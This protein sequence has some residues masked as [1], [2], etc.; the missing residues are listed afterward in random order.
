MFTLKKRNVYLLITSVIVIYLIFYIAIFLVSEQ[1]NMHHISVIGG[2]FILSVA[3][4]LLSRQEQNTLLFSG[5]IMMIVLTLSEFLMIMFQIVETDINEIPAID[6]VFQVIASIALV[7]LITGFYKTYKNLRKLKQITSASYDLTQA[8]YLEYIP[9]SNTIHLEFSNAFCKEYHIEQPILDVD[10]T[11]FDTYIHPEDKEFMICFNKADEVMPTLHSKIRFMFPGMEVYAYM[12]VKGSYIVDD[13]YVCLGFDESTLANTS[14]ALASKVTEFQNL[15]F[16]SRKIIDNTKELISKIALDGTIIYTS[17]AFEKVYP[18]KTGT[19]VGCN[20]F[21]LN[22]TYGH[23]NHSWFYEAIE[24]HTSTQISKLQIEGE[25]VWISWVNDVLLDPLGNVEFIISV[26]HDITEL[27]N[28]NKHLEY[29]ATHN[30]LTGL[31]NYQGLLDAISKLEHL[32]EAHTFFIDLRQFSQIVDYYGVANGESVI[33]NVANSLKRFDDGK[34][35]LCRFTGDQFVVVLVNPYEDEVEDAIS[36]LN[37]TIIELHMIESSQIQIK[38]N[39]GY[40]IYP[41]DGDDILKLISL[42]SLA[43]KDAALKDSPKINRYDASMSKQLE[44]NIKFSIK[45]REAITNDVVDVHFQE[46]INVKKNEVAFV[47]ALARWTDAEDGYIRPDIF[48]QAAMNS[49]LVHMLERYLVKKAIDKFTKL[50]KIKRYEH[51]KLTINISPSSFIQEEYVIFI[52]EVLKLKKVRFEDIVIEI[53]EKTFIHNIDECKRMIDKYKQIGVGI[54]IDDFGRE[55]SSLSILDEIEYDIIKIDGSF[56]QNIHNPKNYAIVQMIVHIARLTNRSVIAES[57]ET[58]EEVDVL[59]Q[60]NCQYQ[61]GY[62][63]HKPEK[64][65]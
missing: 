8:F 20:M 42:S 6:I 31:L 39:I 35:L 27:K 24:K 56:I 14:N 2:L 11:I 17:K 13:R 60:L 26:G 65:V 47:E 41:S 28:L 15:E 9:K 58:K 1:S 61:Q 22:E 5:A 44:Q 46:V 62:Y 19:L 45:L 29:Q 21:E 33:K 34:N 38:K 43:M 37:Q 57:V 4:L 63:F 50:K 59:T 48:I 52:E 40:A 10:P 30:E 54:A 36:F 23:D 49:N 12:A 51:T 16:E 3:S 64:L 32:V 18:T 53:S 25:E 7:L 55:Y